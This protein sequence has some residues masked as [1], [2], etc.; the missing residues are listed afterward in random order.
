MRSP[1][2]MLA[3]AS[4]VACSMRPSTWAGTPESIRCGAGPSRAGQFLRTSSWLPPMPPAVTTTACAV[5][6]KSP[7]SVRELA[8]PRATELG[9][10]DRAP[11]AGD[12]P[13]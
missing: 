6:S 5:S 3:P 13:R 12:G 2:T 10:S 4:S 9:S 7:V 1:L 11:D 8:S